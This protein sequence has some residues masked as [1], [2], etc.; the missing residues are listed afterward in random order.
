MS[1]GQ[2]IGKL[3]GFTNRWNP[4]KTDI[5]AQVKIDKDVIN[6]PIDFRQRKYI[7]MEHPLNSYVALMFREGK[8][9]IVSHI[10]KTDNKFMADPLSLF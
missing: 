3:V 9:Q 10:T 7:E 6:V 8:W 2:I 5:F 4:L 1:G